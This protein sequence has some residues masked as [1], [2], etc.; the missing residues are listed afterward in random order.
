MVAGHTVENDGR[1]WKLTLRDGLVFHDGSKVLA[2]DCMASIRRW[3]ARD[4]FGQTLMQRT[5]ELAAPDE[6][7]IVFRLSK[8]FNPL[9]DALGKFGYFHVRDHA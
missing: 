1:T 2:R 6:R 3:S 7:T 9:P 5:D 8:P 4:L